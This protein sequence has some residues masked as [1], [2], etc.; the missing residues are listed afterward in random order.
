MTNISIPP[1]YKPIVRVKE[2]ADRL[3]KIEAYY[4]LPPQHGEG[5]L[6]QRFFTPFKAMRDA[7]LWAAQKQTSLLQG[8]FDAMDYLKMRVDPPGDEPALTLSKFLPKFKLLRERGRNKKLSPRYINDQDRLIE[9]YVEPRFGDCSLQSISVS[10]IDDWVEHLLAEKHPLARNRTG[11]DGSVVCGKLSSSTINNIVGHLGRILTIAYKRDLI[12]SRPIIEKLPEDH[13]D[14][15]DFLDKDELLRLFEACY[16]PYGNQ[17]KV[18]ALTGARVMETSGLQWQDYDSVSKKLRIERQ[19]DH[20]SGP[21]SKEGRVI[22]RFRPPK[23][24]SKRWIDVHPTL[25]QVLHDQAAH[26][27]LQDDLIFQTEKGNPV[28]YELIR[29]RL[30]QACRRAGLREISPHVLR[31]T[32][33]SHRIMC[34]DNPVNVQRLAGHRSIEMTTK[35]YTQLG[36]E[37]RQEAASH[38]EEYLFGQE[39]GNKPDAINR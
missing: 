25:A 31:R 16:G 22:S 28:V 10:S 21:R 1:N 13:D 34:G 5:R 29:R 12:R 17:I 23:W 26:T 27:R 38:F 19:L 30:K 32:F 18:M 4:P 7:R 6:R 9:L 11:D 8:E 24:G 20:R 15:F 2:R 37:F 33:I 39:A 35:Y 14:D 3:G 36:I